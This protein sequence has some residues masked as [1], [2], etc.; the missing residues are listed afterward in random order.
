LGLRDQYQ[1]GAL[2]TQIIETK[3]KND[4][5]NDEFTFFQSNSESEICLWVQ[6]AAEFDGVILNPGGFTHTSVAIRDAI[7][8][9]V[10]P[11]IEVH[12]SN[13][14]SRE[15]FRKNHLT[16]AKTLGYISGFKENSYLAG[17]FL[18]KTMFEAKQ[19]EGEK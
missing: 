5:P 15:Y 14:S 3:I 9:S 10:K 16:S 4:F 11:I 8:S 13:I 1:Y 17:V 12:L 2:S 7:E 6:K 19:R 18:L